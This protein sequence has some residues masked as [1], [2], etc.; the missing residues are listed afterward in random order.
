MGKTGRS[1]RKMN[2]MM[3][4]DTSASL[5]TSVTRTGTTYQ[6]PNVKKEDVQNVPLVYAIWGAARKLKE[7][8]AQH[9]TQAVD[10]GTGHHG[11]NRCRRRRREG[12]RRCRRP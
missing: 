2:Q 9:S 12:R 8:T 3:P 11:A 6:L 5:Q 1:V 4:E 10:I 7:N